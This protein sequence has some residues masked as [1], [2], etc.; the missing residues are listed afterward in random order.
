[1]RYFN[2][3]L[4]EYAK[5]LKA[6]EEGRNAKFKLVFGCTETYNVEQ[7]FERRSGESLG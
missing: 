6:G 5:M 3:T 2:L 7:V 4:N 1:M